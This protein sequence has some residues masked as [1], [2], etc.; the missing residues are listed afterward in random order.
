MFEAI[1]GSA[2]DIG[3]K[4]IANPSGLLHGAIMMLVHIG[5]AKV[6]ENIHN[7]WLTTIEEGIHTADIFGVHSTLQVGTKDFA[8]AVIE[9]LG[10]KPTKLTPISYGDYDE[11]KGFFGRKKE[12]E[13][14][15]LEVAHQ[16]KTLVGVDVFVEWNADFAE[17][18]SKVKAAVGGELH[19]HTIASKGLKVWPNPE[20]SLKL[21]DQYCCRVFPNI[22]GA[23][24]THQDIA[25]LLGR[26][27][28]TGLDFIKTEHL[29]N[30]DGQRG[31]TMGQGE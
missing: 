12:K 13:V 1:H 25:A 21:T 18:V 7:A 2:P 4:G 3:G 28:E 6:A 16:P 10:K 30:F 27:A 15:K 5:Q 19:L 23:E 26:F 24:I 11:E 14:K 8:K 29:Y 22:D 17:L 9:R 31:Y 20:V